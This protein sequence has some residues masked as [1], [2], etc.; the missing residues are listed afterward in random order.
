MSALDAQQLDA[1]YSTDLFNSC[2][3]RDMSFVEK[4]KWLTHWYFADRL[5][6]RGER[7]EMSFYE[8]QGV[9]HLMKFFL[10]ISPFQYHDYFDEGAVKALQELS[11]DRDAACASAL[12]VSIPRDK[13]EIVGRY[14]AQDFI[15]QRF[16]PVPERQKPKVLLDF[17]AGHG[18][19]ANLGFAA[20]G[21][22]LDA[23]VAV[24]GIPGT[25]LTQR[26]YYAG[27]NL[28]LIDYIDDSAEAATAL[29]NIQSTK[30]VVHLPTW[31]MDL[32]PDASIDMVCCVQ[33]LKELP[34]RLVSWAIQQF[35]RV[36]KPEGA[37]YIRDHLQFH[38]P[39]HMPI[40]DLLRAAGFILEFQPHI[41]DRTEIHGI[42][43]IWRKF[44]PELY[45]NQE[46]QYA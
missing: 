13:L 35:A 15:L 28:P 6:A 2:L 27:H 34:R 40:D 10:W 16:Y 37:I 43:R 11:A 12:G 26:A 17:G 44:N 7:R 5:L 22:S 38:N 20:T 24:D 36:L 46:D 29:Q 19:M 41:K 1:S 18:R 21:K 31:R 30:G 45:F 8:Y 32:I 23:V 9:Q 4:S 33:V 3:Q 39:S 14:N 25:Y 42:P